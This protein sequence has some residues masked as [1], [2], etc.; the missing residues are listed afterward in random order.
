MLVKVKEMEKD[1]VYRQTGKRILHTISHGERTILKLENG[2]IIGL[3]QTAKFLYDN[4]DGKTLA[5]LCD[6][7]IKACTMNDSLDKTA[8]KRDCEEA[9]D[10]LHALGLIEMSSEEEDKVEAD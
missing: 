4:C 2:Q 10:N 8:V 6:E 3:N 9:M 1:I 5:M 7:L